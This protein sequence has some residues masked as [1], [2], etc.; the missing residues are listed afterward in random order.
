M[1]RRIDDPQD[2]RTFLK[3][4]ATAGGVAAI[5]DLG[6]VL[7][8]TDGLWR[9]VIYGLEPSIV[10]AEVGSGPARANPFFAADPP[11]PLFLAWAIAWVAIVL[12]L[13]IWQLRRRE[14]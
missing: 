1:H 9:G 12:L 10:I 3:T 14:L 11:A 6:R 2:R 4:L 8:P 5:G 13:A 7:L